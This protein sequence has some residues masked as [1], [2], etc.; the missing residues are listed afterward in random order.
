VVA[1][2]DADLNAIEQTIKAMPNYFCDYDTIVHF[3][4]EEEF[5]TEHTKMP[6]GGFVFRTGTTGKNSAHRQGME[7]SLQLDSNPEFTAN[8]M[9]AYA[10]AAYRIKKKGEIGAKTVFDIPL[11]VLL[12]A[13]ME[14]LRKTL[15]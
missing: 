13:P 11:G 15:L 4:S 5:K 14:E 10:R 8:V 1:E 7:F 9:V 3:I 12:P 6:H 2:L